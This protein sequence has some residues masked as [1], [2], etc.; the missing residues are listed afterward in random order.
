VV[1]LA[2]ND[3]IADALAL[4]AEKNILAA[5]VR[6]HQ[7]KFHDVSPTQSASDMSL[8]PLTSTCQV[9][10]YPVTTTAS[11]DSDVASSIGV[12]EDDEHGH[13]ETMIGW[14][15]VREL[16]RAFVV[17]HANKL[18]LI[19]GVHAW[20]SA[21][22]AVAADFV[23]RKLVSVC[24]DDGQLLPQS[25]SDS[26][27][28]LTAV[29]TG[30]LSTGG[31]ERTL[32]PRSAAKAN[33]VSMAPVNA[34]AVASL[35]DNWTASGDGDGGA[36][37][38][39]AQ[40]TTNSSTN[41][42]VVHRVA[43]FRGGHICGILS[44]SDVMAYLWRHH[45]ELLPPS[46]AS[47]PLPTLGFATGRR[48]VC[49]TPTTPAH[50][51]F[52]TMFS[53][54]VSGVGV[55][56]PD[57]RLVANLSASDLRR[58]QPDNFRLLALPVEAFLNEMQAQGRYPMTVP[59]TAPFLEIVRLLGGGHKGLRLHRVYICDEHGRPVGVVTATDVLR[60]LVRL[61]TDG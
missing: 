20:D 39:G 50:A 12:D 60:T 17:T 3:T 6:A 36:G 22:D 2:H 30:F 16:L 42:V 1:K 51:A 47:S 44:Q 49:V 37:P 56:G 40:P 14:A 45:G 59:P 54:N 18:A 21:L 43:L 10:V 27:S 32:T 19:T 53:Y 13:Q 34:A 29:T 4:L 61:E 15:D 31:E 11:G 52:T 57:E 25:D 28:L 35:T 55:V 41:A 7:K 33:S 38:G 46:L 58:L 23:R 8:T 48:V 5:P 26:M 9:M 24:G